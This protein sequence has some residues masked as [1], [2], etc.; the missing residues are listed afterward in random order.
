MQEL[1]G[2]K[3]IRV[4]ATHRIALWCRLVV[5]V[6]IATVLTACGLF[7]ESSFK[8]APDSRLPRW[9]VLP[10]NASREDVEVTLDYFV[11]PSGRTFKATLSNSHGQ[12]LA[13]VAGELEGL[14]PTSIAAGSGGQ[15]STYPMYEVASVN[16]VPDIVEHRA[17]EPVFYMTDDPSVWVALVHHQK[18]P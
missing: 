3:V 17:M 12:T 13:T 7:P 10:S 14:G 1:C 11:Q 9:L 2:F 6:A 18:A 4:A 8:L 16:G 15:G 5:F